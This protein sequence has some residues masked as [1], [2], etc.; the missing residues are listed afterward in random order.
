M[1]YGLAYGMAPLYTRKSTNAG[2]A[3]FTR[4]VATASAEIALDETS[5]QRQVITTI[6]PTPAWVNR[7]KTSDPYGVITVPSVPNDNLMYRKEVY[8]GGLG[9]KSM[10]IQD[11]NLLKIKVVYCFKMEIPFA[12]S[13]IYGINN[14]L[15]NM[16]F[17]SQPNPISDY[18]ALVGT[19]PKPGNECFGLNSIRR[20]GGLA[21]LPITSSAVIRMQSRYIGP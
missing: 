9:G 20:T 7:A 1:K 5:N 8:P 10:T 2:L 14:A 4:A 15:P 19:R 3:D 12:N 18:T 6:N 11:G 21:Y 13:I 16:S 17:G